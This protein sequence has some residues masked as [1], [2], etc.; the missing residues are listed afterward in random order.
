MDY[1]KN[2]L[3]YKCIYSNTDLTIPRREELGLMPIES[4]A[5]G[6]PVIYSDTGVFDTMIYEG[7]TGNILLNN[8]S[9]MLSEKIEYYINNKEKLILGLVLIYF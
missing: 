9:R 7:K 2:P 8:T 3:Y 6:V 4:M 1:V 5:C